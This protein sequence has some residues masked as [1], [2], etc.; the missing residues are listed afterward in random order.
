MVSMTGYGNAYTLHILMA[1]AMAMMSSEPKPPSMLPSQD[2]T[3]TIIGDPTKITV[4]N[5]D[6]GLH[7]L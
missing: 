2:E 6:N 7:L 5:S 4:S 1:M 3:L